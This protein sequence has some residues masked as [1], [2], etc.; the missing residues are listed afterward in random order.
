[1]ETNWFSGT[2]QSLNFKKHDRYE[3]LEKNAAGDFILGECFE[4]VDTYEKYP[5]H[6]NWTR[7]EHWK[8]ELSEFD[9]WD[10]QEAGS[11]TV[12]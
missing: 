4:C 12:K 7:V 1:M 10:L 2:G 11:M 5:W 8:D 6:K 3:E 9:L